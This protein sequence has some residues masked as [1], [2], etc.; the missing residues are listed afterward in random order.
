MQVEK[1]FVGQRK[2]TM[3]AMRRRMPADELERLSQ[4]FSRLDVCVSFSRLQS[5]HADYTRGGEIGIQAKLFLAD[6]AIFQ[7]DFANFETH[8]A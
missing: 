2:Q 6:A 4:G 8:I 5:R 1:K 3:H 7:R